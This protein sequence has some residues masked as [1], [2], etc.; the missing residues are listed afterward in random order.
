M[1]GQAGERRPEAPPSP[2]ASGLACPDDLACPLLAIRWPSEVPLK[3]ASCCARMHA[4]YEQMR[5]EWT[6]TNPPYVNCLVLHT[7]EPP[8]ALGAA[9]AWR[10]PEGLLVLTARGT[11]FS[12]RSVVG[13]PPSAL[14]PPGGHLSMCARLPPD[15]LPIA[16][17]LPATVCRLPADCLPIASRLPPDCLP[18]SPPLRA[19]T[20]DALSAVLGAVTMQVGG[21]AHVLDRRG[22][23]IRR[24]ALQTRHLPRPSSA[25]PSPPTTTA[26]PPRRAE[27]MHAGALEGYVRAA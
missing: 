2:M 22:V 17:R 6:V 12:G 16:S 13:P 14:P 3:L 27:R 23:E 9:T 1:W 26:E 18:I 24:G 10:G 25:A 5:P 11:S 15:S 7:T 20:R 21:H 4:R 19:P 8:I